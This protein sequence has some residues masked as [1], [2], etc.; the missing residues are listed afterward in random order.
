MLTANQRSYNTRNLLAQP[1][2]DA[3]T[4][5]PASSCTASAI[6]HPG[7]A[8]GWNRDTATFHETAAAR[9]TASKR[10]SHRHLSPIHPQTREI[11]A[12]T[13]RATQAADRP[14]T[15]AAARRPNP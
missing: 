3:P 2:T 4:S 14:E 13:S 15:A 6:L 9:Q 8:P 12:S 10:Y 1:S 5:T 11:P 7:T